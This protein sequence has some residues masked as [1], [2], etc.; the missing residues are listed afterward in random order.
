M[1]LIEE[2]HLLRQ[3]K[4]IL[5]ELNMLSKVFKE[6][7]YVRNS[8]RDARKSSKDRVITPKDRVFTLMEPVQQHLDKVETMT[9]QA[10]A[11]YESVGTSSLFRFFDDSNRMQL[12]D[13]IDLRQKQANLSE[14]ISARRQTEVTSRQGNTIMVFTIVTIIFVSY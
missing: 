10:R 2:S 13:L 14:A 5:D 8:I 1:S 9:A 12:K 11:T 6:Q 4:D 7:L 3:I